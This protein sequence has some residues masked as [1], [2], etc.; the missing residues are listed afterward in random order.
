MRQSLTI[1]PRSKSKVRA[2]TEKRRFLMRASG[3]VLRRRGSRVVDD[4]LKGR[5]PRTGGEKWR[6]LLTE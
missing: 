6:P 2:A 5:W 3:P 1:E 4:R